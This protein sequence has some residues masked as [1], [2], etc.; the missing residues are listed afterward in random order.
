[1]EAPSGRF[2]QNGFQGNVY[3]VKKRRSDTPPVWQEE[4]RI[5]ETD[6][7][8]SHLWTTFR[9]IVRSATLQ[10][11]DAGLFLS[12]GSSSKNYGWCRLNQGDISQLIGFLSE[13]IDKVEEV[14]RDEIRKSIVI[15]EQ[16]KQFDQIRQV[17]EANGAFRDQDE[18]SY[19]RAAEA[20]LSQLAVQRARENL[21]NSSN[22]TTSETV[23][24]PTS[25]LQP[26]TTPEA[27]AKR[28]SQTQ[29]T[30]PTT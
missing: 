24:S 17:A 9:L 7:S 20:I 1:M 29:T 16:Q 13:H 18:Q 5:G 23:S 12:L 28:K 14:Y 2:F 22:A 3:P 19:Q 6:T 26:E 4:I 10:Y 21:P 25:N 15:K 30:P 8:H 27:K 11:P